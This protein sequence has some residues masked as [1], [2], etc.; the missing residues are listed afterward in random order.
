M[1]TAPVDVTPR[2][3]SAFTERQLSTMLRHA[4]ATRV[5]TYLPFLNASLEQA[6]VTSARRAAMY[7]AQLAHESVEFRWMQEVDDGSAYEPLVNPKLAAKLGNTENGDGRKYNGRGAIQLTGKSNYRDCG[8]ALGIDLLN[9]PELA[10][11]PEN[12]FRVAAWF[13]RKHNLGPMSDSGSVEQVTRVING[14]LNGLAQRLFYYESALE[15]L[16]L[17]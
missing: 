16:G 10:S 9:R 1:S 8:Q 13:W 15:A 14:G 4:P 2:K 5:R 12:C 11:A 17:A 7:L 3:W 6:Q